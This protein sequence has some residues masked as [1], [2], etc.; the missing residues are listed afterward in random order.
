MPRPI[1]FRV[2]LGL[3]WLNLAVL[4]ADAIYNVLKAVLNLFVAGAP[5]YL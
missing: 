4:G 3:A 5:T 1:V 2:V